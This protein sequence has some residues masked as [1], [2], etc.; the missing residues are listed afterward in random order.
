MNLSHSFPSVERQYLKRGSLRPA[1]SKRRLDDEQVIDLRHRYWRGETARKL[2]PR[3]GVSATTIYRIAV[4]YV[5][6]DVGGPLST[7]A[8]KPRHPKLTPL[9]EMAIVAMRCEGRSVQDIAAHFGRVNV[10]PIYRVLR[11]KSREMRELLQPKG[12]SLP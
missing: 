1:S 8:P 6:A 9:D 3:Y 2:A 10:T 12:V 11:K 7:P 5:Y 4:G